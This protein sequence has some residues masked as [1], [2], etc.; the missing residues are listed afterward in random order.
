MK[1]IKR[2]VIKRNGLKL[3][4]IENK[5]FKKTPKK[6]TMQDIEKISL[7]ISDDLYSIVQKAMYVCSKSKS[8]TAETSTII[9]NA[10]SITVGKTIFEIYKNKQERPLVT[11]SFSKHLKS[12]IV[13]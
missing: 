10:L 5:N 3:E 12:Q 8:S 9:L 13:K 11:D 7:S 6:L 4:V 2:K 1:S